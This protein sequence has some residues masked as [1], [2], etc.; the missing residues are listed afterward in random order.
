MSK[1]IVNKKVTVMEPIEIELSFPCYYAKDS[2]KV[3]IESPDTFISV[4][5]FDF[6]E[7]KTYGDI[8]RH[9]GVPD[10]V[11]EY[12]TEGKS[13]SAHDFN[14]DYETALLPHLGIPTLSNY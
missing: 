5:V 6:G 13:I 2:N 4:L 1:I 9:T 7:G 14:N 8:R 10:Q 3:K 11:S 12:V